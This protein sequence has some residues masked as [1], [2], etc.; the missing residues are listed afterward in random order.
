MNIIDIHAPVPF[1]ATL[2]P[3]SVTL[4]RGQVQDGRLPV[5]VTVVPTADFNARTGVFVDF[6]AGTILSEVPP[7]D[8]TVERAE[9]TAAPHVDAPRA[10]SNGARA[11][12]SHQIAPPRKLTVG[13]AETL[14]ADVTMPPAGEAWFVRA[15]FATT[16]GTDLES[17][18][19]S[20]SG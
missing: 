7:V 8:A 2:T 6:R 11:H 12:V 3:R 18:W 19:V 10:G 14:R 20:A 1:P 4:T 13:Q 9:V 17:A 16:G 5:T 15:R